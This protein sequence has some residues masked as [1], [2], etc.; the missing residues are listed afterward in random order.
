MELGYYSKE[1]EILTKAFEDINR[2]YKDKAPKGLGAYKRL[3]SSEELFLFALGFFLGYY[4]NLFQ[5]VELF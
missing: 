5:F 1:D 2:A 4:S 3:R